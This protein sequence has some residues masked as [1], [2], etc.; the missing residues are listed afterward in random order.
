M[1]N[2]RLTQKT[3]TPHPVSHPGCRCQFLKL[4][5]P[6]LCRFPPLIRHSRLKA[7]ITVRCELE[8]IPNQI[9]QNL[10]EASGVAKYHIGN[11][12][13]NL[14]P[15]FQPL[16]IRPWHEQL[17][18]FRQY[19]TWTNAST[20]SSNLPASNL[21]K[22]RMS[23]IMLRSAIATAPGRDLRVQEYM[24]LLRCKD[25]VPSTVGLSEPV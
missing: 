13:L 14:G 23:L 2:R 18:G 11:C 22:S 7:N 9:D 17:G 3:R 5:P 6:A 12:V 24:G 19:L 10:L 20:S 8:R 16:L 4:R 21:E 15:K 1:W 25:K